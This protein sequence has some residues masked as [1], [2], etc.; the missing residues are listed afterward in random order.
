MGV[1]KLEALIYIGV[2]VGLICGGIYGFGVVIN[3]DEKILNVSSILQVVV[4]FDNQ[5][6]DKLFLLLIYICWNIFFFFFRFR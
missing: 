6:V 4:E 1:E 5:K 2:G 3:C